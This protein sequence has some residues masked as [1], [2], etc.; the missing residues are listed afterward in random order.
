MGN[1]PFQKAVKEQVK[2]RMSITGPSGSGKTWTA[3]TMATK[4]VELE[5]GR[6]ALLDTEGQS[7]LRYA[8]DFDF[9]VIQMNG[10]YSP[11]RYI[12]M[13]RAAGEHGYTVLI[14]D[15]LTHAWNRQGG[16]LEI[17]DKK[18][19]GNNKWSGW[20]EARPAQNKLS[21]AI[22]NTPVHLI[23]TMREK[24]EWVVETVNGK[25]KPV[26]VGTKA[27]QD[28][29]MVYEFDIA[30]KM[31]YL[32][33]LLVDKSRCTPLNEQGD[34]FTDAER[35]VEI[36]HVW[37]TDGVQPAPRWANQES[38]KAI[39][40]QWR[41]AGLSDDDILRFA[42]VD[43]WDSYEQW[44]VY[45]TATYAH[46]AIQARFDTE[47]GDEAKAK[48]EAGDLETT[49]HFEM[50]PDDDFAPGFSDGAAPDPIIPDDDDG[51]PAVYACKCT[52]MCYEI[53]EKTC[54]KFANCD[55]SENAGSPSLVIINA[56]GRSTTLKG[57]LGD[58]AYDELK[59]ARYDKTKKTTKFIKMPMEVELEYIQELDDEGNVKYRKA[60]GVVGNDTSGNG[61]PGD[62][63]PF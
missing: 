31:D 14:I 57:W 7:S 40:V 62:D 23:C 17:A 51:R 15:S 53:A 6:I 10:D 42:H 33:K 54:V 13:I 59:L 47:F 41:K 28:A 12:D 37:L 27:I 2:G 49:D 43:K 19:K 58:F 22:V 45:E 46:I 61:V 52:H 35:V 16:V 56:Y 44:G 32:H 38:V 36:V 4:L 60:V 48:D 34:E 1:N 11:Q 26:K 25:A 55:P 30:F 24:T 9:D 21:D 29:D 50:I 18:A 20:A 63:I 8:S 39:F 5:G 3:L